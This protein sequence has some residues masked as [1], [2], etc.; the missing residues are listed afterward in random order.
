MLSGS[1]EGKEI[2]GSGPSHGGDMSQE[3]VSIL[4]HVIFSPRFM[5]IGDMYAFV[6]NSIPPH[7]GHVPST[8]GLS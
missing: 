1:E 7:L 4:Q 8:Q 2:V 3:V 5:L 6:R